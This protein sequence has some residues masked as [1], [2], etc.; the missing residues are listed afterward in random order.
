MD[1]K[2]SCPDI[3]PNV[4]RKKSLSKIISRRPSIAGS[5]ELAILDCFQ[6]WEKGAIAAILTLSL[7]IEECARRM[8]VLLDQ[9]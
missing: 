3:S 1:R 9:R 6:V 2:L 7:A 8:F 4:K 5:Q